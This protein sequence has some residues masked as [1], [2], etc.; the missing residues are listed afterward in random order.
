MSSYDY[1]GYREGPETPLPPPG[2]D[3]YDSHTELGAAAVT[4]TLF[5]QSDFALFHNGLRIPLSQMAHYCAA[6]PDGFVFT[7]GGRDLPEFLPYHQ[8]NRYQWTKTP[9]NDRGIPFLVFNIDNSG[10][11]L[12]I[13]TTSSRK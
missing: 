12:P 5:K 2:A 10:S 13:A 11:K 6:V 9:L 4:V 1:T 7:M 8:E 3:Y